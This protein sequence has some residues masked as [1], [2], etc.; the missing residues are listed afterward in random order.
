LPQAAP[1]IVAAIDAQMTNGGTP[2]RPALEGAISHARDWA[3]AYPAHKVAVV[4][5]TDGIPNDCSSN[6]QNVSQLAAAGF[7]GT[8]RVPTYV[9]GVGPQLAGLNQIAQSGG[10]TQ[11][12]IVDTG[13]T[14]TQQFIDAM[15]KIRGLALACEFLL[16][17]P[18]SGQLDYTKV[19]V[20]F[21]PPSGGA[22]Q[23]LQQVPDAASCDPV[24]GGW[25]YDNPAA[26]TR[27]YACPASC[28]G[29][30]VQIGGK[31]DILLGCKTITA[32]PK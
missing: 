16:P 1:G 8:P 24:N 7:S 4:L 14:A 12:Y 10:T 11:A 22:P 20:Q 28:D 6:I 18:T 15:N 25:Y 23:L 21:T 27:I 31:V 32:P 17:K 30:N 9:I 26:P 19:N 13:P 5:A 3:T 29:F 2:T